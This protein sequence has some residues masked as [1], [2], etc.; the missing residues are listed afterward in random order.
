MTAPLDRQL[1]AVKW[2]EF[3]LGDLFEILSYKKRFDANKVEIL[4]IGGHPYIVRMGGNNGQKGYIDENEQYLNDGNTISFGQDTATMFYQEKPYFTGDKIKILSPKYKQFNKSNAQFFLASMRRTFQNF[5]WGTSSF[6]V[7]TL[8]NQSVF[9]PITSSGSIDFAFMENFLRELEEERLRELAAYL[10]ISGL[11]NCELSI[12]ER[13]ALGE[14]HEKWQWDS[15]SVMDIFEVK[16]THNI[17]AKDIMP[18][19]GEIPYLCASSENN[20]VSSF[21]SYNNGLLEHGKCIFI[22]GKTFVVTC[23]EKD[24]YSNDSHNLAL[25]SKNYVSSRENLLFLATCVNK[26]L[27][28]KYTWGDSI[29]KSK[30]RDDTITLPVSVDAKTMETF[31]RAV[32]KLVVRDVV[33]WKDREIAAMRRVVEEEVSSQINIL[34]EVAPALRYREYLPLYSLQAACGKFGNGETV[35][36]QGWVKVDK[37]KLDESMFVVRASGHSM[38]PKIHDGDLC[39]MRLNPIGT[40]Q[41]KIVLAQHRDVSDPE[42]GGA[43]SIKRYS[44]E[45]QTTSDGVWHHEQIT[46]SPLN[47]DYQPIVLKE[48][49]GD[50]CIV[51]ELVQVLQVGDEA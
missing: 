23:Q 17:L 37:L 34:L 41:G 9:L 44:S 13:K 15:E 10:T 27:G 48:N 31:I 2:G 5:S 24:F 22:G 19:S 33:S 30:I 26:S 35:K 28:H 45:K 16:N 20:S 32:Q 39:V 1:K 25:Y 29:S 38:E 42:T 11:D 12:S 51:A 3:R 14:F 36:C 21:I 43:Y 18:N 40:R 50:F 4:E 49:S 6:N 47:P 7:E 8:A 46:L